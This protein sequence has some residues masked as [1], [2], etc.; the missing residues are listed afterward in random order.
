MQLAKL[1]L[2]TD[3]HYLALWQNLIYLLVISEAAQL[4]QASSR[5][6]FILSL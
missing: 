5:E 4:L 3:F 1:L 6:D 2:N